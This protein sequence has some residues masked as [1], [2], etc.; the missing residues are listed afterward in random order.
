MAS[1]S[2]GPD[3]LD[4]FRRGVVNDATGP[5]SEQSLKSTDVGL[6]LLVQISGLTE[7]EHPLHV[8]DGV[9]LLLVGYCVDAA[10][11][12]GELH[13]P[14]L[15]AM[16]STTPR[17]PCTSSCTSSTAARWVTSDS[18]TSMRP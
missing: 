15:A 6:R 13:A 14:T 1:C 10:C 2:V 5:K 18:R 11:V 16:R 3:T 9:S 4:L 7:A 17:T 8:A 12:P